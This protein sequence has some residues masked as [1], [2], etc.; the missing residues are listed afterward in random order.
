MY[1]ICISRGGAVVAR[2]AHNLEVVGAIPT[3]AT[4]LC[5][6]NFGAGERAN[7][8]ARVRNCTAEHVAQATVSRGRRYL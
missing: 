8:F 2:K 3:P 5:E 7:S 4:K 1:S 6:A